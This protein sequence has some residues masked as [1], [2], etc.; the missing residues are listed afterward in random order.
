MLIKTKYL[1]LVEAD[2]SCFLTFPHGIYGFEDARRFALLR[3]RGDDNPFMWLQNVDSP[4]PCF[5]VAEPH[6]ILPPYAP[7]ITSGMALAIG[8]TSDDALR[9]LVIATV[10]GE[11]RNMTVNLKCP[12]LINSE[13]NIAA[14]VILEDDRYPMR[15]CPLAGEGAV[16]C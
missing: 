13:R 9:M 6:R 12:V 10:P 1:G 14:Q 5:I 16:P 8:L 11:F 7:E 4:E 15:F 3:N 2:E